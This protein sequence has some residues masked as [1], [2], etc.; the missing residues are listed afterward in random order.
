MAVYTI[1]YDNQSIQTRDTNASHEEIKRQVVSRW[2]EL[3]TAN[4]NVSPNNVITF[5]L[6]EGTKN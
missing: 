4:M 3:A 6:N 1:Q 5:T 2:P